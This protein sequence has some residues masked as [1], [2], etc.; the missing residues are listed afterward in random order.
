[1]EQARISALA[2]DGGR[3]YDAFWDW[4]DSLSPVGPPRPARQTSPN[5]SFGGYSTTTKEHSGVVPPT[6]LWR[7]GH[8]GSALQPAGLDCLA[9]TLLQQRVDR[10]Q[11][12]HVGD[13]R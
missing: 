2:D 5:G 1:M 11:R 13:A 10:A 6:R 12:Q 7:S 4:V 3:R 8:R 9:A